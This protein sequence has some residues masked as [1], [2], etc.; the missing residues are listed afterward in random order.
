[1]SR[2]R[3]RIQFMPKDADGREWHDYHEPLLCGPF[4]SYEECMQALLNRMI[5]VPG[6]ERRIVEEE[7]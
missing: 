6:Y 5:E 1:M 3:W 2:R 7:G 4:Y